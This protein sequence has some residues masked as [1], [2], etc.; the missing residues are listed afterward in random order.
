[1]NR[2]EEGVRA[3]V[4]KLTR[5]NRAA[6]VP[7]GA[8]VGSLGKPELVEIRLS[9]AGKPYDLNVLGRQMQSGERR[10]MHGFIVTKGSGSE[11]DPSDNA[12]YITGLDNNARVT[13]LKGVTVV[14]TDRQKLTVL[15]RANE[16]VAGYL[17]ETFDIKTG[18]SGGVMSQPYVEGL[19][20]IPQNGKIEFGLPEEPDPFSKAYI[21][22]EQGQARLT[23]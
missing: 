19:V 1:M 3:F 15:S 20:R 10:L 21:S 4:G 12:L 7:D 14:D 16:E 2:L 13:N 18:N 23:R 17:V 5:R 6:R 9:F 11:S 22:I 8:V